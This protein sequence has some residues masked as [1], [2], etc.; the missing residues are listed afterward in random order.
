M[1]STSAPKYRQIKNRLRSLITDGTIAYRV[2]S[3]NELARQCHVSRM[4]ARRALNELLREGVVKRIAGRGT[5]VKKQA[6]THAF[7]HMHA[8]SENA[9]RSGLTARSRVI[10][11]GIMDLP[12][13]LIGRLPGKTAICVRRVHLLDS[14]PVCCETR[15]LRTDWCKPLLQ[16]DLAKRSVHAL[17]AGKL[18]LPITRVWQRLEAV[19][20][21]A[22]TAEQL[23]APAG[24]AAFCMQQLIYSGDA[25]VS[26]VSYYLRSDVYAFEDTF[27][28]R[29]ATGGRLGRTAG[30]QGR[31]G[32]RADSGLDL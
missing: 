13:T 25:P 17:I 3:E 12:D 5:F 8:F 15:Y 18:A 2:P 22:D 11:S 10:Q 32:S 7:F 19:R 6:V 21:E 31:A 24:D 26:F 16:E 30:L 28:P 20:L 23:N 14:R 1:K 29:Q 9:K 27:D 4:T